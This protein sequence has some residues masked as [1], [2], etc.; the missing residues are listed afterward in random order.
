MAY[1][2]DTPYRRGTYGISN[3]N[4]IFLLTIQQ[5]KSLDL[6]PLKKVGQVIFCQAKAVRRNAAGN[7]VANVYQ[8]DFW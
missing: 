6:W 1:W 4:G 8:S 2:F 7:L 3:V 5:N